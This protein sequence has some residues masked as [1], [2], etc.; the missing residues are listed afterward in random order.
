MAFFVAVVTDGL[1]RVSVRIEQT[2]SSTD[3]VQSVSCLVSC[4][5]NS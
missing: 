2:Y 5:L 3:L 1:C 4:M